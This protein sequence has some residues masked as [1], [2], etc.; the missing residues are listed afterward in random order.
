MEYAIL[1]VED[2]SEISDVVI[3]YLEKEGYRYTVASTGLSALK[4]FHE[5]EFQMVLLD[6]MLPDLEGFEILKIIREESEVPVLI[7]SAKELE[8]D[9][10]KGFDLGADDYI[11]KP[12]SPRELMKRIKTILKRVYTQTENKELS[13]KNL[14]L[15]EKDQKVTLEGKLLD[16][17]TTEYKLLKEFMSHRGQLLSRDQLI[18]LAFG[19]NYEAYDRNIDTYVKKLRAKIETD[20]RNPRFIH[21]K[22][23]AGYFFGEE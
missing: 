8:A 18:H 5:E 2:N 1:V 10:L 14:Y 7:V 17:T 19:T 13:Y 11:I 21:T 23:G 12:F 3:K 20:P 9:R 16:L 22:Y 4:K 15:R 6:L